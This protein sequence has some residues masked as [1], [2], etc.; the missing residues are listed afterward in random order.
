[1]PPR[2]GN[3]QVMLWMK[4]AAAT[5]VA[6]LAL[7]TTS[8]PARSVCAALRSS[9]DRDFLRT[10]FEAHLLQRDWLPQPS[11]SSLSSQQHVE[12]EE[13][14]H[15]TVP[16]SGGGVTAASASAAS[17]ANSAAASD[18]AA[19]AASLSSP[20]PIVHTPANHDDDTQPK[21]KN[22][23]LFVTAI[24]G[25]YEKTL[26]E[27]AQQQH[28]ADFVAFTDRTDLVS[29]TWQIRLVKDPLDYLLKYGGRVG[30]GA[31][32]RCVAMTDAALHSAEAAAS[33]GHPGTAAP[34]IISRT[35]VLS[36][37]E[38]DEE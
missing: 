20:L 15:H 28:P 19:T 34:D 4:T 30:V 25:D 31:S 32:V 1:M 21:K 6:L 17:A 23:V 16:A 5:A 9:V 2:P 33:R 7:A 27:P 26:K 36:P 10:H 11:S 24:Y 29:P 37:P 18:S 22:K 38:K 12:G 13:A 14:K 3:T 8:T 35:A